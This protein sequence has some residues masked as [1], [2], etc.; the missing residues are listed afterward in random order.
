MLPVCTDLAHETMLRLD[1]DVVW[2]HETMVRL[3]V[4]VAWLHETVARLDVDAVRRD[5][6]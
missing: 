5:K 1:V 3:D 4:D 2:L 6:T